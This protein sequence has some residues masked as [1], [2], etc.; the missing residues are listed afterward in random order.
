MLL[1]APCGPRQEDGEGLQSYKQFLLTLP[2]DISPAE[3]ERRSVSCRAT[4]VTDDRTVL[5]IKVDMF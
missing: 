5:T 4:S 3:G 2:D 1:C